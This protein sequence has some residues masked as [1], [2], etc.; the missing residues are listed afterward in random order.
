[1]TGI[2]I[3]VDLPQIDS[4]SDLQALMDRMDDRRGFFRNV[5]ERLLGS[6]KDN[7]QEERAPQGTPWQKLRRRTIK[8]REAKK[9]TPIKILRARGYLAGSINYEATQDEL[10]IGSPVESAA[11]HQLG[12]EIEKAARAAKIYRGLEKG[13]VTGRRFVKKKLK[14]KVETDV[15]IGAHKITIPARPYL[16]ISK[17][18]ETGII[19]DA[20]DW[21]MR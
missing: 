1:M 15:T 18:D 10:R 12:G 4:R 7:F 6:T 19:E 20:E 21:L 17:A 14:R 5:G 13:G 8:A 3:K 2:S 11:I 16:G 9:Q